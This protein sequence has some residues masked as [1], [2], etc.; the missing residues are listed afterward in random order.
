MLASLSVIVLFE[1]AGDLLRS[2]LRLPV[3]GP[4]IGMALLLAALAVRRRLPETLDHAA[5]GLLSYLPMLFVPA[6]VG[7]MAHFALIRTEWPVIAAALL[8]SSLLTIVVTAAT[9][10]AIERVQLSVRQRAGQT[11][12]QTVGAR[13]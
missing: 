5:S 12:K 9:M 7:I 10:I 6:G 13:Q 1:L 3:P 8:V 4:V 11:A 2:L